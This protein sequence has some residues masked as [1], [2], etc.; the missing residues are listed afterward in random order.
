MIPLAV[1]VAVM[2]E[3]PLITELPPAGSDLGPEPVEEVPAAAAEAEGTA[4][5][6]GMGSGAMFDRIAS[7]YDPTNKWMSLGLDQY[8]RKSLVQECLGLEAGDRV[9]D[10]ATGTADVSLL[11]ASQLRQLGGAAASAGKAAVLGVDP[12]AEMLRRGVAKVET[13]GFDG[14]VRLVKGDAQDLTSVR[15]IDV[16]G[17]LAAPTDG[18][19]DSSIDKISMSFGI[20]NVP[21]R[22]KAFREMKRVLRD[23]PSSRVCILEFAL[24]S[25]ASFLSQVA[26]RFITHVVPFLGKVATLGGGSDEYKY[27]ERSILKF[28][29]PLDFAASMARAGLPVRSI[30]SF[31]Y[32]AVHLYRAAPAAEPQAAPA[33][34]PQAAAASS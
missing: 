28:P 1:V 7:V 29:K 33:A 23:R 32:G 13:Q 15:G 8:W 18:V 26:R 17:T 19:A 2:L 6:D 4:R 9:L 12:S 24:P 11:V 3:T 14:V 34:E 27:L 31:A 5:M 30:T 16:A 22:T 25:G 21:D 20:R 10:L